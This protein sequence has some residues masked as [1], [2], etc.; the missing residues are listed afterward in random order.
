MSL[1]AGLLVFL[2]TLIVYTFCLNG[3]WAVDHATSFLELDYA[4]WAHHS[5]ALGS[6]SS[7]TPG[8]VDDFIYKGSYYSAL[9]PGTAILGLPFAGVGFLL[10][11]HFTLF[12]YSTVTAEFFVAIAN[13]VAATI[14]YLLGRLLSF[15]KRVS[16]FL[17][18]AYAF[19]TI[20][21]PFATYFFQSDVSA[22]FCLLAVYLT[23]RAVRIPSER[24][25]DALGAGLAVS[26]A[27]L[28]DYINAVFLPILFLFLVFS[29]RRA[30]G[31]LVRIAGSF[32]FSGLL[33]IIMI[34]LYNY[35]SFGSPLRGS[36]QLYLNASSV[37]AEFSY[38][39]YSGAYLNLF[40]P[41]RGLFVFDIILVLGLV[42]FYE[43]FR[44]SL[45]RNEAT[46]FLVCFLAI[47]VPYSMWYD[48]TGGEGFGPRFLVA[49]IPFMLLPAGVVLQ[50]ADRKMWVLAYLM[51]LVG[52]FINGV[53]GV[54]QAVTPMYSDGTFPFLQ[55]TFPLFL[56]D[57][58]DTWWSRYL[59]GP[60]RLVPAHVIIA[61]AM[62]VPL[63]SFYALSY[64]HSTRDAG[65][66]AKQ[67]T[68]STAGAQ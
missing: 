44:G 50:K 30:R 21:W 52:V 40:T 3:V 11:G 9:A 33:G 28:V 46:L 54:T 58:L 47:F 63:V 23:L 66:T 5:F 56:R 38:P 65:T 68:P 35:A 4:L 8:T 62:V 37:F 1:T 25:T 42:G 61:F 29:L 16:V 13:A 48:P 31:R 14:V 2:T 26:V 55:W 27:M 57:G 51:Y 22:M 53:A 18:F 67:D 60:S 39:L 24:I 17:G 7:F 41:Y 12:G 34:G 43:M 10:D 32:A 15:D 19:S 64:R 6:A 45:Y 20:S 49:A 59:T 36:E